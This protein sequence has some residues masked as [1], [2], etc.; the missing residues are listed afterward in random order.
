MH[1]RNIKIK[2]KVIFLAAFIILLFSLLILLYIIPTVNGIIE[3]RTVVKLQEL[4]DLPISEIAREQKLVASGAKT[5]EEAQRDAL[6][7]IENLRYSGSEYFWVNNLE[8]IMVMHP[9]K[10]E[11]DNTNVLGIQDPDGK[12][13]FSEFVE[14]ARK[15]GAGTVR[16]QWPKPGKDMPQPKLS[17]IVLDKQWGWVVGTGVYVDDL[18]EIQ[19]NIYFQVLIMSGII[20][21]FSVVLVLF[22]VVPLNKTLKHI[23]LHT[24]M[25]K[26][27]DFTNS[28]NINSKDELG[29]ISKA[30]DS[31]SKGLKE[32]LGT[33]IT[34]SEELNSEARQIAGDMD[35]LENQAGS[36]LN[37]TSDI[38][39]IIEETS[40]TTAVVSETIGEIRDAVD[41]V[42]RKATEGAEKA[43]DVSR[44]A[45]TLKEDALKSSRE[46]NEIFNGVRGRLQVAIENARKVE[47][48]STLLEGIMSITSQTNLLALNASIEAARAGEAGRGFAVVAAE[49]GK[50]ADESA[51]LVENIQKTINFIKSAVNELISDSGEILHFIESNVLKDY[52][53]LITIGDQY[54]DDAHVFNGIMMD[55]SAVSEEIT[56]SMVSIAESMEEVSKATSQEAESVENILHM[57]KD[58]A[59][60]S[61]R[62]AQIMQANI[63]RVENLDALINQF[64]IQ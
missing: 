32:L 9:M 62:V 43:G 51:G 37:S 45:V 19:R 25:Y 64:K 13:I 26:N 11:L 4:A 46:A 48:I 58:V 50:L 3:E 28:I 29:D 35:T 54:N 6:T 18:K 14:L 27:L 39:A 60:K 53:K 12:Y 15:S 61:E 8:G 56:S 42:A 31:V 63:Q 38:S 2:N 7:V 55:L 34:T 52:D 10:P 59:A 33:M 30:F 47:Q 17:Y 44:R 5:L 16:Y 36:T 22:I 1:F 24:D 49:V 21:L 40:A 23:I 57:T 41:V 20:I